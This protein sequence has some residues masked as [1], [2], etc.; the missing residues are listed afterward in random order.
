MEKYTYLTDNLKKIW[1]NI[2]KAKKIRDL[3]DETYYN[4]CTFGLY[5]DTYTTLQNMHDLLNDLLD[6]EYIDE[7]WLDEI[8]TFMSNHCTD[9]YHF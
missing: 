4:L 6:D 9:L 5:G 8:Y 1:I 2:R 3:V 7:D